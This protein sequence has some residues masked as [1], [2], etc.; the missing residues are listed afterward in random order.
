LPATHEHVTKNQHGV[1]VYQPE[2]GGERPVDQVRSMRRSMLLQ[3][4]LEM[5]TRTA[6]ERGDG[7]QVYQSVDRRPF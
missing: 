5:A 2:G 6:A 1:G 4:V 3:A 7:H